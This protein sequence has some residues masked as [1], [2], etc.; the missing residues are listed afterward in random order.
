MNKEIRKPTIHSMK[1]RSQAHDYDRCGYYHITMSVAKGLRQPLGKVV[2]QLDKPDGDSDAPHVELTPIG[3]MVEEELCGSIRRVYPMLE[4]QD[5]VVM[6]EHLHFLLVAHRDVVSRS[7]KKTHLGNVIAGFKYGC[8]RRYWV[9]TGALVESKNGQENERDLATKS[10]GTV[11]AGMVMQGTAGTTGA[12][13]AETRTAGVPERHAQ[14]SVLG[15]SVAKERL[16]ATK[17]L[18]PLFEAGY[19]DVMPVDAEQLATQRAYIHGNPRSRLQRTMNRTWLQPQRHT[20]DTAVSL[21]ALYGYLQRECPQQLTVEAIAM[22]EKRL[23]QDN[24]RVMCDSYGNVQLLNRRLLPVVCHRKDASLFAQQK[25]RCLEEAA[26]GAVLVS[27]RISKGEQEILDTALLSGYP[28]IRIEDN[29][30]AD[31]YHPSANRTDDCA[32]GLLLLITPWKYQYRS[33]KESISV[34]FCKA[35]NCIVQAVCRMK[36][37]WWKGDG[38]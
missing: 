8:N 17:E 32:A 30:F 15:D 19:C 23:L 2:G 38:R 18:T 3:R 35:M 16:V 11:K 37:S 4:V 21:R 1:R 36:D 24:G 29:G 31:I 9:M 10:P 5:Y 7:G 34:P 6:P 12:N 33:H 22:L 28:V 14:N 13:A 27:A 25:A 26:K 20:I